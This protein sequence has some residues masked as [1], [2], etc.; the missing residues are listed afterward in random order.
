[1]RTAIADAMDEVDDL[2]DDEGRL[3]GEAAEPDEAP[4]DDVE[5]VARLREAPKDK[6][7]TALRETYSPYLRQNVMYDMAA[8]SSFARLSAYSACSRSARLRHSL[9]LGYRVPRMFCRAK[10][11][12]R[13]WRTSA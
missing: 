11:Q 3:F 4:A 8:P 13:R 1:M 7:L 12:D 2:D 6:A 5:E 10:P 9:R